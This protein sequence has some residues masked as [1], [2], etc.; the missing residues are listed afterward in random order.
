L[1][2]HQQTLQP[3][4]CLVLAN[5]SA[6]TSTLSLQALAARR[7]WLHVMWLAKDAP[8]AQS[9]GARVALSQAGDALASGGESP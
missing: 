5:G 7:D 6:Q 8:A 9:Q 1:A 3:A 2:A 4:I